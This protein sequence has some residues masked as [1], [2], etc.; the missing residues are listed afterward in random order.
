MDILH[1][2]SA[3][4]IVLLVSAQFAAGTS[5]PNITTLD[6]CLSTLNPSHSSS[7]A[8]AYNRRL[9]YMPAAI[10]FPTTV[11]EVSTAIKCASISSVQ[12]AARSGGHSYAANGIGG[13]NGSLVIDLRNLNSVNV[14]ASNN[15]AVFGT[16]IRLG[17]LALALYDGGNQA[18]AH[19][20]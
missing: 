2:A 16:G 8:L 6:S 7:D 9:S 10:V 17:D 13:Q 14:T 3:F 12:V 18:I 4:V 11:D 20:I 1:R 5:S 15:T 19:G